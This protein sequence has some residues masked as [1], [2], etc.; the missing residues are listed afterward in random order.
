[1]WSSWCH[2]FPKT[3]SFLASFKSIQVLPFWY[4][5]TQAVLEKRPLNGCSSSSS[6]NCIQWDENVM[7]SNNGC[8]NFVERNKEKNHLPMARYNLAARIQ[9]CSDNTDRVDQAK[10]FFAVSLRK[11]TS[12]S[13]STTRT[14]M[15]LY[16]STGHEL[17]SRLHRFSTHFHDP[18]SCTSHTATYIHLCS[19]PFSGTT[20]VC[21]YQ[22]G[23]TNL[24]FTE[25]RDSEWQW[26]QL[27]RMQVCTSLQTD[28]HTSNPRSPPLSFLQAACPSCHPTNSIK[29]LNARKHWR[30]HLV[31]KY[32]QWPLPRHFSDPSHVALPI[33]CIYYSQR[34]C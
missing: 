25:A 18:H 11:N 6:R 28:N 17:W 19:G 13:D 22:K 34:H 16:H 2:C 15:N 23:K 24:D 12:F 8:I 31:L 7:P 1:M 5:L 33:S 9:I 26:H 21:R 4:R 29:A 32:T 27:G 10:L 14:K 3:S 30:Q 20:R